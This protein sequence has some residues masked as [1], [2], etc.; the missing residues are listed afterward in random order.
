MPAAGLFSRLIRSYFGTSEYVIKPP[1]TVANTLIFRISSVKIKVE[2]GDSKEGRSLECKGENLSHQ[3]YT[4]SMEE[5]KRQ[6]GAG[7]VS[8]EAALVTSGYLLGAKQR[9]VLKGDKRALRDI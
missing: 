7:P 1:R 2:D 8:S 3:A 5:Y 6:N 4:F 9:F